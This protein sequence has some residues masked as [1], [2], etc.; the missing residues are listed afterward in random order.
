[1][2][3]RRI[4][5]NNAGPFLG[6][7][8]VELPEGP[9]VVIATYDNS[10]VKSNRAGKS[11]FAVDIPMYVMFGKF[12]SKS[13]DDFTHRLA[14][15]KE[16]AFAELEVKSSDNRK[17]VIKRGRTVGGN[18]ISQLNG[19]K[20]SET[21]L[22]KTVKNEILGLSYEEYIN[23]NAFLQSKMHSF[24]EMGAA[25]KRRIV[26]P[27]FKTDRWIPRA[28]L[29]KTRLGK[30]QSK[31]RKLDAREEIAKASLK[32]RSLL[33]QEVEDLQDEEIAARN[34]LESAIELKVLSKAEYD[35]V[36]KNKQRR[37]EINKEIKKLEEKAEEVL[38]VAKKEV[39]K[40]DVKLLNAKDVYDKAKERDELIKSFK[41]NAELISSMRDILDGIKS[42]IRSAETDYKKHS[43]D[44][45]ELLNKFKELKET[46]TGICPILRE[47]CDRVV[48]DP[49][50]FELITKDGMCARRA[51]KR[52][53]LL[54]E[55]LRVA[56]EKARMELQEKE[57]RE[58]E[59]SELRKQITVEEALRLFNEYD[60]KCQEAN[61]NLIYR[62]EGQG[63][64]GLLID[65]L[66]RDLEE[67]PV[68]SDDNL[69]E[70]YE[71]SVEFEKSK[72]EELDEISNKLASVR[73]LVAETEHA[74]EELVQIGIERGN[75]RE[76]VRL[77][78][79]TSYAFG[80]AGI[81]SRELEN[82]FGIAE[83][84]MN[85]VLSE[86]QTPLRV[87]FSPTRELKDW[88]SA[89]LACGETFE[90]GERKHVC[91]ACG[92]PRK[93]RRRDELRL[94]VEDAGNKSSFD[95]DSGGGKVLL[96]LGAR[97]GLS[98]LPRACRGVF[99]EHLLIDEPDGA[100]DEPNRAALHGLIQ[101]KLSEIGIRQVLL[102]THADVR[103]EFSSVVMVH[104]WEDEDRSAVWID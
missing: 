57:E 104:R 26:S 14:R 102:I 55:E 13:V 42:N 79:W 70:K 66:K 31:L 101:R 39:V 92:T 49:K 83:D 82:A 40:S 73:A 20:I 19:S 48:N 99:C 98:A 74:A 12:R 15:G 43:K 81:P 34:E 77:L 94:E 61:E 33:I 103:K 32:N 23:T 54:E 75:V 3:Y 1:M 78:A 84:S 100:L 27:W 6:E 45:K 95:L 69:K 89:C 35:K 76:N 56:A 30:A 28:D 93:K 21:E 64:Y 67:I 29:A 65:K 88:E 16:D 72:S 36:D 87:F 11:Y 46:R 44:R 17:W 5:V 25:E 63:E 60:T 80:A 2:I 97:L 71:S 24:M 59:L 53:S 41:G 10:D 96:S 62:E 91:K 7:W 50:I 9:T 8:E 47:E 22:L 51:M 18:A 86:L 52:A 38:D 4:L 85:S 90:K 37:I 58:E 68:T